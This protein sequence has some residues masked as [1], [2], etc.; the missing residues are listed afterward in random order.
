MVWP[1]GPVLRRR[2]RRPGQPV[3]TLLARRRHITPNGNQF[4]N[5]TMPGFVPRA[6]IA[7]TLAIIRTTA[8]SRVQPTPPTR[9]PV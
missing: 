5:R 1:I 3:I 4:A 7:R 2:R 8:C 9:N 6:T